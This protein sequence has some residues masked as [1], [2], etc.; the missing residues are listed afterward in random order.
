MTVSSSLQ[1]VVMAGG[2]GSRMTDLTSGKAKCLL[3]VGNHPLVWYPL[4][5]L[6]SAGFTE[7]IV[8]VP[9]YARQEVNKIPSLYNLSIK[10]DIVGIPAQQ[11]LGTAD[12]LRLVGEKLTGTD[13]VIVSGDL[14]MEE[15]MRGMVDMHRMNNSTFTALLSKPMFDVKTAVVPGAKSTKHKKER[16]LIGLQG[17]QLCLF[18][19]EAD[20]EEEVRISKKVLRSMGRVTV[21]SDI[22]D[23]H[24]YVMKKWVCDYMMHDKNISAIKGELLPILVNKQFSKLKP[25]SDNLNLD[26]EKKSILDFLPDN[27]NILTSHKT[28]YVCSAYLSSLPCLRVN[29][30]PVYWEANKR[31]KGTMLHPQAKIGEKAQLND[32]RVGMNCSV[33]DK[34]T[35]TGVC[36]GMGSR[37]EEKVRLSNCVVM[38]NVVIETGSNIEDSIICDNCIISGKSSV[39]LSILGRGQKTG[40][41][42]ELTSQLVLD[43]DRMMEV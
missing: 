43:K 39:K 38:D 19:A 7:A 32:C 3:P 23:C 2:K 14:V 20:V 15:S 13:I 28:S 36:L 33:S 10:L 29:T 40:E 17:D 21:H 35:L 18:T 25:K 4:N 8:I 37:V 1:A 30:V 27:K 9:D 34:T 31:T 42:A 5:M 11:E 24:L 41:G 16:D 22:Q 12:S 6:Q 26:N